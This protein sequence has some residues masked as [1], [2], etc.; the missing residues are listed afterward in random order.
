MQRP[1]DSIAHPGDA[2]GRSTKEHKKQHEGDH[3]RPMNMRTK[4]NSLQLMAGLM[5]A[6][7]LTPHSAQAKSRC[8]EYS[9]Y[10]DYEELRLG[11]ASK[12]QALKITLE[13]NYDGTESCRL[14]INGRFMK[15][16]GWTP[17]PK[18]GGTKPSAVRST[19]AHTR[20][21]SS[22][23]HNVLIVGGVRQCI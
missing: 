20:T 15:E 4:T 6:L 21:S 3:Q 11:G 9:S 7:C 2:I 8:Y 23:C 12:Q 1:L 18:G 14:K 13:E 10:S 5:V 17:F 22:G 16:E 19:P